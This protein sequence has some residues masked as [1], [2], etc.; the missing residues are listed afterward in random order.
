MINQ[1]IQTQLDMFKK[2]GFNVKVGGSQNIGEDTPYSD[3][4]LRCFVEDPEKS[5]SYVHEKFSCVFPYYK[6]HNKYR[7]KETLCSIKYH[8]QN[9][10]NLHQ[11][12]QFD[13]CF[14][15]KYYEKL[16]DDIED[17]RKKNMHTTRSK[18][19]IK[20][21]HDMYLLIYVSGTVADR[22]K[23]ISQLRDIKSKYFKRCIDEYCVK[24]KKD[25]NILQTFMDFE[26]DYMCIGKK[27]IYF[28]E[29]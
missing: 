27:K 20:Q 8:V 26:C 4:D 16:Y 17:F 9:P 21:K 15:P 29:K 23:Y 13:L 3:I 10:G 1:V 22:K 6:Y 25:S 14:F 12:Y 5:G 19:F 11:H 24:T 2:W 7:P 28:S 18:I